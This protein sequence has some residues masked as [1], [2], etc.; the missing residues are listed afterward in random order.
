MNC[1]RVEQLIALHA[2]GDLAGDDERAVARHLEGCAGCRRLADGFAQ[3]RA[4]LAAHEPPEFDEAFFDSV[5]RNVMRGID[6]DAPKPWPLAPFFSRLFAP[7]VLAYAASL[8]LLV[9]AG[10][11]A[12]RILNGRGGEGANRQEVVRQAGEE[13]AVPAPT[14]ADGTPREVNAPRE[15]DSP[16]VTPVP[17]AAPPAVVAK[18]QRRSLP[19]PSRGEQA[20]RGGNRVTPPAPAPVVSG[21]SEMANLSND[22]TL[23]AAVGELASRGGAPAEGPDRKMLRIEL[24]TG[25]PNVRIIWLTP[26]AEGRPAK[27]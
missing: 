15:A 17:K 2:G 4:L 16:L 11:L 13:A 14:V 10:A 3:S 26:Q 27:D 23:N 1:R 19:A 5:R 22:P 21:S 8:A 25:D 7:R 18:S 9:A 20:A 6:D 24:R 12:Y